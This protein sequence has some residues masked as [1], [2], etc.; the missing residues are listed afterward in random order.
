M[1]S[2][3]QVK[4]RNAKR[5]KKNS[6]LD[7]EQYPREHVTMCSGNMITRF[8]FVKSVPLKFLPRI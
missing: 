6:T 7:T 1:Q 8:E 3:T 5:K 4:L 2:E